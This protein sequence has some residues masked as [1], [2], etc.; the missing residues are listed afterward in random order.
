MRKS[1]YRRGNETIHALR[2][3]Y[4]TKK[5]DIIARLREF[6]AC[7]AR[8]DDEAIFSELAFC[9]L[10]PQTKAHH[11]WEAIESLRESTLLFTGDEEDIRKCLKRVRFHNKKAAYLVRARSLLMRD[12]TGS[13]T[14][15]LRGFPHERACREWLVE[16]VKGMGYKEASHF[17]RNIGM[18]E[19][20]AILDRHILRNLFRLRVIQDIP[21]TVSGKT[22]L[23][24]ER[25]MSDF[26]EKIGIPLSH[27]DLLFWYRET[28]EIFK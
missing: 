9:L 28:G 23:Q 13:F 22:Y 6:N 10:T 2:S 7:F 19:T 27:L 3:L 17:L 15:K 1:G 4:R 18:G 11:C 16:N 24:I 25:D 21:E 20:L 5:R 12:G 8:N 14:E 26:A